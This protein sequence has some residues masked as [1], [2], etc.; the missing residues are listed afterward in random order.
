M[1]RVAPRRYSLACES[2][3]GTA[4]FLSVSWAFGP[5]MHRLVTGRKLCHFGSPAAF[6]RSRR[7]EQPF[8][9]A[10]WAYGKGNDRDRAKTGPKSGITGHL[11]TKY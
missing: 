5:P 2:A 4:E 7:N 3:R 6:D 9:L 8:V 11:L 1:T 10:L